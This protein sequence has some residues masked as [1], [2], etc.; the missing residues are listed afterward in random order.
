MDLLPGG[1]NFYSKNENKIKI[2]KIT[3]SIEKRPK[4]YS[5]YNSFEKHIH[6]HIRLTNVDLSGNVNTVLQDVM[7]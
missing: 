6:T 4:R 3:N 5:I 1:K 7:S 2:I